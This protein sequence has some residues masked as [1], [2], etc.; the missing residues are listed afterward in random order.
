MITDLEAVNV[1]L[2]LSENGGLFKLIIKDGIW[3]TVEEQKGLVDSD[4]HVPITTLNFEELLV[5]RQ[6][7]LQGK[8]LLPGFVDVHMHLDKAYSIAHVR[9]RSGTLLEAIEN[10]RS[11]APSFSKESIKERIIK[12]SMRA[13]SPSEA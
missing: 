11:V 12:A 8:V 6:I 2:P 9:N 10:Y 4:Q 1:R 5:T 13:A 7:D 3:F